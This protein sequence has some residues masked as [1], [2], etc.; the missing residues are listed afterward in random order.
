MSGLALTLRAPPRQR[1]DLSP[2]VP[3]RLAGLDAV[4]IAAIE[5][6]SGNRR[7]PVG[8]L[9]AVADGDPTDLSIRNA[10]DK[11]DFIGRDMTVGTITV[12]GDAGAYLG[13]GLRGGHIHVR[14]HVGPWA[15]AAMQRGLIEVD[16]NA[17]DFAAGALPG[18]TK[19]MRGGLI[20]IHGYAGDRAG[21][22]MRRGILVIEGSAGSHAGSRMIAG[23]VVVLGEAVGPYPGFG[24]KRGSL[25]LSHGPQRL[26]P[27]FADCGAHELGFL[28]LLPQ[29]VGG[30][31]SRLAELWAVPPRV[32]RF[33]GDLATGGMGEILIREV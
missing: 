14:G 23:T 31:S 15:G 2:L 27:T 12:E 21:D 1:L 5:L 13:L 28:K 16:G 6:L 20:V 29:A 10:C 25:I 19:G 24:M 9:F 32:R 4:A 26:S 22:L 3:D 11:L 17:G 8:E 18:E 30:R 7:L 33:A